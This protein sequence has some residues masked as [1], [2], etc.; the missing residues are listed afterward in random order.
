M[1]QWNKVEDGL[2]QR[3]GRYLGLFAGGSMQVSGLQWMTEFGEENGITHWAELHLPET[4]KEDKDI[5][6]MHLQASLRR[7]E[8]KLCD[9]VQQ[10][11]K[12]PDEE[13]VLRSL[14]E[15]RKRIKQLEVRCGF[16]ER[17]K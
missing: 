3:L 7:I 6:D 17:A 4:E 2:P 10:Q 12:K 9:L 13:G 11:K 5:A 1:I 15:D 14:A 8:S 16:M